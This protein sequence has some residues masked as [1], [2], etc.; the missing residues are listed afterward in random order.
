MWY[1]DSV[2]L[3][4]AP[5]VRAE[6]NTPEDWGYFSPQAELRLQNMMGLQTYNSIRALDWFSQLADVDSKR[7]AVTGCSG[8]GTQTFILCAV[9]NR[10]AVAFPAVM[11][12]TAM[13][14]GCTCANAL[15]SHLARATSRSA[16]TARVV[17][18][19]RCRRLD[20]VIV[21]RGPA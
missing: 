13:Q 17:G 6:M 19:V 14:G 4:H 8:G 1:A 18:D 5:R 15:P 2:Q 7:I 16:L 20:K 21:T 3:P 9:D 12:S 10:P 11:V